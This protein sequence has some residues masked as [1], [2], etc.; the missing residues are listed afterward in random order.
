[1]WNFQPEHLAL[2]GRLAALGIGIAVC[3]PARG[4]ADEMPARLRAVPSPSQPASTSTVSQTTPCVLLR[5][6][7]VLFGAA[8][9]VGQ[10]VVIKTG[11][12]GE[13]K[14]DRQE[15]L[16]W[17]D[18]IRNLY[19]YRVDHRQRGDLSAMARDARWCLRYDLYDLVAQEI[20]QIR[21]LDP[22]NA[23]AKKIE[24]QLR[25]QVV[26]Q[27]APTQPV[28]GEV[29]ATMSPAI[30]IVGYEDPE[31]SDADSLEVDPEEPPVA[32]D[33]QTLHR[34]ASH[35][36]PMLSNRCGRCHE[37]GKREAG[38]WTLMLPPAGSRAS[39]RMTRDNL[40]SVLVH[41][42]PVAPDQ[43]PLLVMATTAHGGQEA[44]LD[45][46]NAKAV[47]LL[48]LWLWMAASSTLEPS[49]PESTSGT[50]GGRSG[51]VVDASPRSASRLPEPADLVSGSNSI[52][53]PEVAGLNL[54]AMPSGPARLPQV[55]NPF[56][57]DLFNR[58]FALEANEAD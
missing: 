41:I 20:R 33:S 47:E 12:G 18:S 25:R 40:S 53:S 44:P 19:R 30:R 15:V 57:P 4:L 28:D 22:D 5:N 55:A 52:P 35:I 45:A 29:E 31:V 54:D 23:E 48:K 51:E 37:A 50:S 38:G 36:Q 49:D 10:F 39:A 7:N 21:A 2:T 16:C 56:D 24:D 11:Q 26:W 27:E 14:L 3:L 58:R 6:D 9:Q 13:I 1:M 43:S 46:R 17:A 34:F 8:R 32:V 42:D